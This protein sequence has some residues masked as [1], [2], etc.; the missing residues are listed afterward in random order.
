MKK[1]NVLVA[2]R[3]ES[4]N[5]RKFVD[6]ISRIKI[7]GIEISVVFME[8]GS[9]D[10]TLDVLRTLSR[11]MDFVK[12]YSLKN[13]FGQYA[14]LYYGIYNCDTDAV[15]TMDVD[16]GHPLYIVEKMIKEFLNGY[17]VVQGHREVY[18][19][20]EKYRSIAS[21]LYNLFF[22]VFVGLNII[23]QNSI[24]RLIDR[25]ACEIFRKNYHWGYSLKTNFKKSDKVKVKYV[26][27]DTPEREFGVSK[28]N[29]L[30]LV[31]LSIRV[32]YSQLSKQ[33]FIFFNFIFLLLVIISLM[34]NYYLG[35]IMGVLFFVLLSVPY[36]SLI[37]INPVSKIK[38]IESNEH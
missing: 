4:E 15:I 16:G 31:N 35:L 11:K 18:N 9:T 2:V 17:N 22:L 27:Y 28:Y 23:K 21:N 26:S 5:I 33:R 12:Y 20:K 14:A 24:F 6:Q 1:I 34:N 7:A 19:Q 25:K 32:A 3:N 8:D 30:R 29:F 36:M 13:D 37:K 10:E 38:I